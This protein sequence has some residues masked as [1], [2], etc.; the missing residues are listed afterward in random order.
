[1][2]IIEGDVPAAGEMTVR[3][4]FLNPA[5]DIERE[6]LETRRTSQWYAKPY[7]RRISEY[8]ALLLYAQPSPDWIPGSLGSG[9][10]CNKFAGGRAPWENYTTEAKSSDWFVFRDPSGRGQPSYV[11]QKAEENA[12]TSR[13]FQAYAENSMFLEL[14]SE[15][16]MDVVPVVYGAYAHVLYGLFGALIGGPARDS[17]SDVLRQAV[18]TG[19]MDELDNAEMIQAEKIFLS[20][21]VEGLSADVAPAREFFLNDPTYRGTRALTERLWGQV[22]DHIEVLFATYMVYKP[23]FGRFA[24]QQYFHRVAPWHGDHLT[25]D[26]VWTTMTGAE[27]DT[28]WALELFG[29]ALGQDPKF[30]EHNRRL[31]RLWARDWMQMSV[32]AM[33]DFAPLFARTSTLRNRVNADD[34]ENSARAVIGKWAERF[35]PVFGIDVDVD[36]LAKTVRAGYTNGAGM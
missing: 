28:K 12:D 31:M 21:N 13:V 29:H 5:Y 26:V 11:A 1:M 35:V 2:T 3:R 14:D 16:A 32:Q 22:Y 15:W 7:R 8:E 27:I 34:V 23:L 9:G 24:R 33:A 30:G 17:L 18:V 4:T 36:G 6:P 10:F 25:A 20:K 19:A